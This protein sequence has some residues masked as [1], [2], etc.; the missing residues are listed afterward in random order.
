MLNYQKIIADFEVTVML[1]P[2]RQNG[3]RGSTRK[4]SDTFMVLIDDT[5]DSSAMMHALAHELLHIV[6]GHF[7][8]F[9]EMSEDEKED[10]VAEM[11]TAFGY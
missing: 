10:E 6:L 11:M 8:K 5:L 2:I 9:A 4:L 7:D 1:R 3:C